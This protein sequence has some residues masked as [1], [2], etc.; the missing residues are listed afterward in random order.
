MNPP[1]QHAHRANPRT[2]PKANNRAN[3][4]PA[5][6]YATEPLGLGVI[7]TNGPPHL[8]GVA[9]LPGSR[10]ELGQTGLQ[11]T[12]VAPWELFVGGSKVPPECMGVA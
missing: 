8:R 9:Y 11:G 3:A 12:Q 4:R 10:V 6:P 2:K 7:P 5:L 1:P